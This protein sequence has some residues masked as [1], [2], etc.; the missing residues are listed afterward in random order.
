MQITQRTAGDVTILDLAGRLTRHDGYGQ[1]KP[2]VGE[3]VAA[4]RQRLLVNL[5][6]VPY[7][8]SSGVGE[9]VSVFI[10]V[11]NHGGVLKLLSPTARVAELLSV[12]KLDTVFDI[13]DDESTALQSFHTAPPQA[14]TPS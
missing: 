6:A 5:Q 3:L 14:G 10:S 4:G 8:D 11:R 9:L 1:L 7:L 12:A 2:R 13:F